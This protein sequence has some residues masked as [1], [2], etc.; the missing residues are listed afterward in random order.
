MATE[1]A[2]IQPSDY[3]PIS[4]IVR[5]DPYPYYEVLRRESPVHQV[6]PGLPFYALTRHEEVAYALHHPEQFSS[7]AFRILTEGVGPLEG[8]SAR[9]LAGHRILGSPMLISVDPPDHA[10]MR[11][12]VNR[13]FTP[14]RIQDLEP[15]IRELANLYL[16]KALS[17]DRFDLIDEF[18]VPLP[19]TVIAE[20]LGIES[21]RR[22]E[23]KHWSDCIVFGLSGLSSFEPGEVKQAADDMAEFFD[24]MADERRRNPRDDLISLLVAAEEGEALSTEEVMTFCVLL[25]IAG[26]ETTTNLIGNAMKALL[27]NPEQ[28]AEVE[29]NPSL[30]PAM[31]EEACR[32][33]SPV[34]GIPRLAMQDI[35]FEGGTVPKDSRV[36]VLM[37]AANRDEARFPDA[38]RFDIH[39]NTQGH[40]GFGHGIHFCLG[41][42]L[43]RL[44]AR[45]AFEELFRRATDFRLE[46]QDVLP[47]DSLLVRGP[48]ELE[49]SFRRR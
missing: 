34:Q 31:L 29:A 46:T 21:G 32:Y 36:L 3:M 35:E 38:D 33:E 17:G 26:N 11:K 24:R 48:K 30:I 5:K 1:T 42:A 2:P 47:H 43:A 14:R 9:T 49:I 39:R 6:V 45:V 7:T 23:F 37:A 13:G 27:Q 41:A 20:L 12:I 25:L 16:D 18:S 44:E 8:S 40:L 10:P 22:D 15:R 19:V 28:R 4:P